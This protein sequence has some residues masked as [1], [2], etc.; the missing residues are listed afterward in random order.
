M[1]DYFHILDGAYC[2]SDW[3]TYK[4][5]L[6]LKLFYKPMTYNEAAKFCSDQSDLM[7]SPSLIQVKP[8]QLY[9]FL[10]QIGQFTNNSIWIGQKDSNDANACFQIDPRTSKLQSVHCS[11]LNLPLCQKS[12]DWTTEDIMRK[13]TINHNTIVALSSTLIPME[14]ALNKLTTAYDS[15]VASN[16]KIIPIGFIYFEY[17][18]QS[19]PSTLWP[20]MK[21][22]DVT[23]LYAG[24]FF[25]ALGGDAAAWDEVQQSCA[26]RISSIDNIESN[27]YSHS[28]NLPTS[29]WSNRLFTGKWELTGTATRFNVASCEVRPINTA[30][31]IWKRIA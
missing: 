14:N 21:W 17:R 19:S 4:E 2:G 10:A 12:P 8:L 3:I 5:D 28:I 30:V 1:F 26:P 29:G 25:R 9:N 6:C 16:N 24:Q 15:L 11:Q 13:I 27:A 31:R 23:S 20:T 18:K 7:Y 22:T